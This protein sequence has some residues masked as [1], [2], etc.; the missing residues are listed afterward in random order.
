[1]GK[2]LVKASGRALSNDKSCRWYIDLTFDHKGDWR[3]KKM[4]ELEGKLTA[5]DINGTRKALTRLNI[6]ESF[7]TLGV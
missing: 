1:M 7:E 5:I 2:G 3:Y 4:E 6:D